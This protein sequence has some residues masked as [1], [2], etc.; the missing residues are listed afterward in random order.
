MRGWMGTVIT[1]AAGGAVRTALLL[2]SGTVRTERS[3]SAGGLPPTARAGML[4][5]DGGADGSTAR[6]VFEAAAPAVVSV[7]ARALMDARS[8]FAPDRTAGVADAGSG[9]VIDAD[10]GL[11]ITNAHTVAAASE[12]VVTFRD[13]RAVPAVALGRDDDTDLA[14]LAVDPKAADLTALELDG[15]ERPAGGDPTIAIGNPDGRAP[16]MTV[17]VVA[18]AQKRL[19]ADHGVAVDGV[20]QTDG[21]SEPGDTGGPLVDAAGHVI[22]VT[23]QLTVGGVVVGFAVPADTVAQLVPQLVA[24]GH[25]RRAFLG[26]RND[27]P[28]AAPGV[29]VDAVRPGSPAARIGL[30]AGDRVEAVAG[31]TVRTMDDLCRVLAARA[32]GEQVVL[33]VSRRTRRMVLSARLADRPAGIADR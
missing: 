12:I 24:S 18:A 26:V 8:P 25:V 17:G 21:T 1:A 11:V 16:T 27:G 23:G 6:H 15:G 3:A 31:E 13:G 10:K 5:G 32:P 33:D 14:L 22:G 19:M 30:R 20:I 2:G 4:G 28:G 29:R 7:H 9:F